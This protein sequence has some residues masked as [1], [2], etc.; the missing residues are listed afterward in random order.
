MWYCLILNLGLGH[1]NQLTQECI[2]LPR[3]CH[4]LNNLSELLSKY[5][6]SELLIVA[7]FN[8]DWRTPVSN[9]LKDI[10][11]ELN[12]FQL[13]TEPTRQN[14]KD[15]SKSILIDPIFTNTPSKYV[16]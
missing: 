5:G 10:C 8:I 4:A 7:N 2:A 14:P 6:R 12:L 13:I 16:A 1:N 15:S 9:T 3:L 11:S